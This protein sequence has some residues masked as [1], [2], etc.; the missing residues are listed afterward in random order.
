M[1][2]PGVSGSTRIIDCWRNSGPSGSVLPITIMTLQRSRIAPED[3]H[4]RPLST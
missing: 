4:L 2:T 3:H 1:F